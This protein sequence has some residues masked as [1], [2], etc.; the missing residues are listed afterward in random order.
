MGRPVTVIEEV[1]IRSSAEALFPF[2][3]DTERMNRALGYSSLTIRPFDGDKGESARFL[4][5]T[6]VGGLDV[7]YEEAPFEWETPKRFS[8]LRRFRSGLL[9]TYRYAVAIDDEKKIAKVSLVLEPKSSLLVPVVWVEGRRQ[10]ARIA[11]FV[12]DADAALVATEGDGRE[13]SGGEG[14]P[15]RRDERVERA[16]A[17][18]GAPVPGL[19]QRLADL[20]HDADDADLVRLRPYE[21]ADEWGTPRKD[22]LSAFIRGTLGGVFEMRWALVCP[23]CLTAAEEADALD[24]LGTSAHC[25]LCELTFDVDLARSVEATFSP[26]PDVRAIERAFFCTGGPARTPHVRVQHVLEPGASFVATVPAEAGSYRLFARG[27]ATTRVTVEPGADREATVTLA[28]GAF[29]PNTLRLAPGATIA[30]A[31]GESSAL[32]VKLERLAFLDNAA[33]AHDLMTLGDYGRFFSKDLLKPGTPLSVSRV[34][35]LFSDLTGST[36]LY[37]R[38]GDA[39]AFRFVDDH[40]D[41]VIKIIRDE[42]GTVVKTMGDAVMASFVDGAAAARAAL[43]MVRAFAV[44]AK[45]HRYGQGAGLKVGVFEGPCYVVN[46]N[47][48]LDYFGQTVNLSSRLQHLAESGEIIVTEPL[49]LHLPEAEVVQ[50]FEARVKGVD[51][52]IKVV[53]LRAASS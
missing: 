39:A 44:F 8:V 51:E 4:V 25:Q 42:G 7:E 18:S 49:A 15:R 50:R 31:N 19:S 21:L 3:S 52:P 22:V 37:T 2:V 40:F 48:K 45:E 11:A 28:N 16:L 14:T 41:V 20:L 46:A 6:R 34:A 35:I 33:T 53:R 5:R 29:E 9:A 38:E 43:G 47:D 1:P 26:H 17:S 12:R 32:H 27:G 13:G 36:A 23:S 30:I 10:L 24:A